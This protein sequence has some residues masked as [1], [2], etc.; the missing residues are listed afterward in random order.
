MSSY[1]NV[2]PRRSYLERGQSK[3][4]LHLG[5]IEKKVDYKKRREIY[6]KKKKIENVLREKIMRKN[7]DEF[8]TG[9]VH[10]RIKENDNILIKEEKVLKEEIKLKNKRGLLNQ[11][12]SYCYKK[13]KK[14]NKIINNFRICV[15]LRYVFNNSHEIFNENEQK[16]ILSTDDK[17]LKKVSELNQKRYNTLI[18]AKKN[19]LKC[20][21]NLENK[22]VSTYRNIDGYTVKNLKGNTPYRFYAPRFR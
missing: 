14:I 2:I 9:M 7:P 12:V 15:P 13:L 8:H 10:S 6:K 20:I 17:K 3:N 21:R 16:Q 22:Y 4:R 11:K 5:E 1:K 18:N 19:I